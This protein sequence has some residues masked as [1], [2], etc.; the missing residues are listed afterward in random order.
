MRVLLAGVLVISCVVAG[1]KPR[2]PGFQPPPPAEVTVAS[3][4]QVTLPRT[5]EFTGFTR[6]VEEV[7]VRARVRG[8]IQSKSVY[9]GEKVKAGDLLFVIDPRPFEATVRQ[10]QAEVASREA[11]YRLAQITLDRKSQSASGDAISPLELAQAQ[12]DRDAAA[13]QVELAKAKLTSAELDLNYTNVRAPI[14]GRVH[15]RNIPDVGALIG[16]TERVL[17]TITNDSKIYVNF[18]VPEKTVLEL[19]QLNEYKHPGVNNRADIPIYV[20]LANDTGYPYVGKYLRGEPGFDPT[21]GTS[22]IEGVIDN[23]EGKLVAGAFAKIRSVVGEETVRLVPDVAVGTDQR[24]RYVMVVND[25]DIVERVD[26]TV[27]DVVDRMRK[28]TSDLDLNARVIINGLQR[29]RPGMVV[30][31]TVAQLEAPRLDLQGRSSTL[32]SSQPASRPA[33]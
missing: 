10:A 11:Q 32:P 3:P 5:L 4:I 19:R 20:G 21:T 23:S 2:E 30:K 17:C 24:G 26:V 31:V 28:I 33:Q 27:S 6:G 9:G 18:S 15:L 12:A 25:K 16:E 7:E 22:T 14:D 1:C 13:A 8:F 29:A